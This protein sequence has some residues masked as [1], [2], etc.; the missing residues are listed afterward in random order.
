MGMGLPLDLHGIGEE[1]PSVSLLLI[2]VGVEILVVGII[3][4][5]LR[6]ALRDPRLRRRKSTGPMLLFDPRSGYSVDR[7]TPP[8]RP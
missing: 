5:R 2:V 4:A 8:S 1:K 3:L 7:K 6:A